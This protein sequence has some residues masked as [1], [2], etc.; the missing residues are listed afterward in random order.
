MGR[1][2]QEFTITDEN[3]DAQK[4]KVLNQ[5]KENREGIKKLLSIPEKNYQN[6]VKP[7]Q[8]MQVK[9]E[10]LFSPIA[11]L[12]YVKNSKKTQEV[13]SSLLPHITEYYT[14]LGQNRD[15]YESFKEIYQREGEGLPQEQKK[16]LQDLIKDFELSGVGLEDEKREKVKQINIKLSQLQNQFAQNLLEATDSY[17]MDIHNFEDV[18]ELPKTELEMAK[19]EENGKTLYR[20]TLHQPSYIAYMTYG[21]N[22]EKRE[23]LY[24]AYTT[25][26]PEN[27]KVL[28]EI[29]AL[30]HQKA[31]LLGFENYA[32]LSLQTKMAKDPEQVIQFLREL[33]RKSKPQ[34]EKEYEQLNQFAQELG[35]KG[36]VEAY[37][38]AY[39]SEKLKKKLFNVSDED[40]KPYFEKNQVVN[41]LFSFL[42]KLFKIQFEKV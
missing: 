35:L 27:E 25:R 21:S 23:Q 38:F 37:D 7:Y 16:V 2:F 18:K 3:L 4:E 17:K 8:L 1:P 5:I 40:Y 10:F 28:E 14:E 32:Q 6:F 41:G 24:K 11:H 22:R 33:A 34:A 12:N 31:N 9:L 26:A 39:Y 30:R 15:L 13:Y 42:E 29:L 36:K 19:V 20:F